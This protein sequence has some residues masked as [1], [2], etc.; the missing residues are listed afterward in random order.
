V[1]PGGTLDTFDTG[2]SWLGYCAPGSG[3]RTPTPT[4]RLLVNFVDDHGRW[5]SVEAFVTADK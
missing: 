1:P 3:G 4:L 5:G 2:V